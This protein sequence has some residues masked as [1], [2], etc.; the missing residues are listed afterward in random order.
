MPDLS[1]S[2][3]DDSHHA[4]KP[5]SLPQ[6]LWR[7]LAA[8]L[9]AILTIVV[10]LWAINGL[11]AYI[12]HPATWTVKYVLAQTI[13]ESIDADKLDHLDPAPPIQFCGSNYLVTR[14]FEDAYQQSLQPLVGTDETD[15]QLGSAWAME[16]QR[17]IEWVQTRAY[18]TP[19]VVYV[20]MGGKAIPYPVYAKVA[21]ALPPGQ[22]PTSATAV[23]MEYVAYN[24]NLTRV[25]LS[26]M[27]ALII[28]ILLYFVGRFVSARIGRWLFS[29]FEEN[30][31]G[32]V[33]LVRNVYGSAKR[34]TDFIFTE[35]QAV[36]YRRVA[37][38]EYPRRGIW[39]LGFIT[40]EGFKE[41]SVEA[42]EPCVAILMPTSPMPMTGFTITVPKTDILELNITIEEAM[43]FCIS[44]GVFVPDEHKLDP[45]LVKKLLEQ[46][47][48]GAAGTHQ[49]VGVPHAAEVPGNGSAGE[50][51]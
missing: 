43:Q 34:V 28:I 32:R 47:A 26:A 22:V 39:S 46:K 11:N 5:I 15:A 13:N 50:S 40:G 12:I 21:Q 3:A 30:V 7:G 44:C 17:R 6:I 42:G 45:A 4:K 33:P 38:V 49:E 16:Q 25:P 18:S 14:E 51:A 20:Q 10:V 35:K 27:T 24:N 29:R 37:A 41:I 9:P 36:E 23:Y 19:P 2:S 1:T 8:S 48:R 31:L